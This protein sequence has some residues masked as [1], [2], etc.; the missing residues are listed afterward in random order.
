MP[1]YAIR[2]NTYT[3]I[4]NAFRSI[5]KLSEFVDDEQALTEAEEAIERIL[6]GEESVELMPQT[7]YIRRLQH[8]LATE[9]KLVSSSMGTEPY[10]RVR[11]MRP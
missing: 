6:S 8:Q 1:V 5:F 10:R 4:A 3:Q 11:I 7:S 9:S 2:S